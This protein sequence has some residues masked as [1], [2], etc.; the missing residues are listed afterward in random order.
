MSTAV[1]SGNNAAVSQ[2]SFVIFGVGTGDY[3]IETASVVEVLRM[4]ALTRLPD[5]PPW[6][7]GALNLRG[8]VLPV[9]DLRARMGFDIPPVELSTPIII[10]EDGDV[11]F[12]LIAD[13]VEG[14]ASIPSADV[15]WHQA[16]EGKSFVRGIARLE[17]RLAF[18]ADLGRIYEGAAAF[19]PNVA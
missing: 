18:I 14:M 11:Q 7:A 19:V 2:E 5:A 17:G 12:G 6:L 4:V 15:V 13:A 1:R 3:A 16:G 10:A 9:I 8:R